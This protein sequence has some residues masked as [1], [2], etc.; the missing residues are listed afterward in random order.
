ML[1]CR[2]EGKPSPTVKWYFEEEL[3]WE[4]PPDEGGLSELILKDCWS[5]DMGQYRINAQNAL[6]EDESSC[7]VI[8]QVRLKPM[9]DMQGPIEPMETIIE[10]SEHSRT[11]SADSHRTETQVYLV[12]KTCQKFNFSG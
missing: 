1:R 4:G 3:I 9:M 8:V 5:E 2:V 7:K 10:V 12:L 6:G 11:T